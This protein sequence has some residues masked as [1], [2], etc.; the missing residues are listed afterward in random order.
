[1]QKAYSKQSW[2]LWGAGTKDLQKA[3]MDRSHLRKKFKQ[4][5]T[6]ENWHKYERLRNK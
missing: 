5:C 3:L 2:G 4:N 1:M 6:S